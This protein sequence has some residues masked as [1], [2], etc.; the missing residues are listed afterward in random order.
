MQ[1]LTDSQWA[2]ISAFLQDQPRGY[3]ATHPD[4]RRVLDAVHWLLRTGAQ[5]RALPP[6]FGNWSSVWD[7]FTAW[8]NKGIFTHMLEH[9][10]AHGAD[11]EWLSFDST[12]VRAHTCA[13]PK[14][15]E[16]AEQGFG[17]S[18][19]GFT[20]K[21]HVKVDSHGMP[22]K[23]AL[24]AGQ[25]NDKIGWPLL[26]EPRDERATCVLAD[27]GYD[28]NAIRDD[29]AQIG[30]QAV[31]PPTKSR[32]GKIDYDVHIY[33]HRHVVECFIGKIKWFRRVFTR[34]DVRADAYLGFVTLA[35]CLVW[36]R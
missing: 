11:F 10:S 25:R 24:T 28:S 19:G 22:L 13:T 26:R 29:L 6:E 17:R 31:I 16:Q 34:F 14:S 7:R 8:C 32:I 20:T 12:T 15:A 3:K 5:W 27:K 18:R 30:V 9:L 4:T 36:M 2:R 33:G 1:K 35:S 23:L 21:L